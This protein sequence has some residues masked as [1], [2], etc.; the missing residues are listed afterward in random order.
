MPLS[1]R[2]GALHYDNTMTPVEKPPH[3]ALSPRKRE[4]LHPA[5]RRGP[6]YRDA[7]QSRIVVNLASA[8]EASPGFFGTNHGLPLVKFTKR[9]VDSSY[10]YAQLRH[11]VGCWADEWV[12]LPDQAS[13]RKVG[14]FADE[15]ILSTLQKTLPVSGLQAGH[16]DRAHES[17]D[18]YGL[19]VA[20]T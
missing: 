3:P 8:Y 11:Q 15:V 4:T 13:Y 12:T 18:R 10:Y 5:P 9:K 7:I 20:S 16:E 1:I 19:L 17:N 14:A 2:T 6:R